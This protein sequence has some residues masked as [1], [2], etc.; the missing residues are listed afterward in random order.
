M[1]LCEMIDT[2]EIPFTEGRSFLE[3]LKGNDLEDNRFAVSQY[4]LKGVPGVMVRWRNYKY[5]T[6]YKHE[7]F[8][9]LFDLEK[10]P[11]ELHNAIS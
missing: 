1:T 8:D 4:S 7:D 11:Q 5:I 9:I 6:Y 2:D 3:A 10:D